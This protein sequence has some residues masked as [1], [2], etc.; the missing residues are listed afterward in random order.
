[1]SMTW[2]AREIARAVHLHVFRAR[3]VVMVPD[4]MWTGHEADLLVV[5][6]DL[7]LVDIEIKISRSDLKADAAKDKWFDMPDRWPF[8]AGRIR[9]PRAYPPKI[10]KHYFCVPAAIWSDELFAC[11]QPISGVLLIRDYGDHP[12]V[13]IKRQARPNKDAKAI[14]A[15]DV[16]DIARLQ[17]NRMWDAYDEVDRARRSEVAA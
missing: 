14:C 1:M 12:L 9:T 6:S 10:W 11:I 2:T 5:R 17:S 15:E 7:R 16:I 3:H 13:T 4:C 8:G